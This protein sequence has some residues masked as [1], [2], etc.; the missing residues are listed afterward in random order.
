MKDIVIEVNELL[1]VSLG[2]DSSRSYS[3]R[4]EDVQDKSVQI[5]WPTESGVRVALRS[6]EELFVSF[7]REDAAY[8][9][10]GKVDKTIS[11]PLPLV[12]VTRI[13]AVVRTQ[14]RDNVRVRTSIPVELVGVPAT[15]EVGG[16]EPVV[17]MIKAMTLDIS[18]GGFAIYYRDTVPVGTIFEVKFKLPDNPD[19][20]TTSAKLM[21]C[22]SGLDAQRN[23]I[24][25]LGL[26]FMNMPESMRSRVVRFV[27][28]VQNSSVR[29]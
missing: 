11:E 21:R 6:G 13:G 27:F 9:F 17:L 23:R 16:A 15:H 20:F 3:S 24:N 2:G 22:M 29:R 26:M 10:R 8:G 19:L 1:Q 7:T 28:G 14:R 5:A 4:A 25:R 12:T 18:G